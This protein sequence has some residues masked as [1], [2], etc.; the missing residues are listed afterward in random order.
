MESYINS[1]YQ[2]SVQGS[3]PV[4]AADAKPV[5]YKGYLIYKRLEACF[6]I[7]KDGVCVAMYAGL[8]GAK[9]KVDDLE[10]HKGR[11]FF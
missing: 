10:L 5:N 11:Y 2:K 4:L 3:N 9:T 6:D 8:N 7:V 1:F